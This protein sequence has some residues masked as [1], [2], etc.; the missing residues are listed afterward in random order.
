MKNYKKIVGIVLSLFVAVAIGFAVMREVKVSGAASSVVPAVNNTVTTSE[1]APAAEVTKGKVV[2]A[3]YFHGTNRCYTCNL[4][5]GYMRDVIASDFASEEKSGR[6]RFQ[7]LD[8]QDPAHQRYIAQYQ[9]SSISLFL[10]L[11]DQGKEIKFENME[12]IWQLSG[13]EVA[14]KNYIRTE[15]KKYLE[16]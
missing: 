7:S 2:D 15:L 8:V 13:D 14:F 4:M 10:S 12:R 5:E 6:L 11:K 3:L 1:S 9:L 16:M